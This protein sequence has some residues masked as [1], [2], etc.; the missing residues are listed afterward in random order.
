MPGT[1]YDRLRKLAEQVGYLEEEIEE[2]DMISFSVGIVAGILVGLI[3]IRVL[4]MRDKLFVTI[5]SINNPYMW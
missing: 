5:T 2:T 4:L 1:G 3:V